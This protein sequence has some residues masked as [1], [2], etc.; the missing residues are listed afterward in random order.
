MMKFFSLIEYKHT[1]LRKIQVRTTNPAFMT[2]A[3][4]WLGVLLKKIRP[5]LYNNGGPVIMVQVRSEFSFSR[6]Y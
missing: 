2:A 3:R 6:I 1:Y 4:E 5:L